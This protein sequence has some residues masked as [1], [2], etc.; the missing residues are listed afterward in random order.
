MTTGSTSTIRHLAIAREGDLDDQSR[1]GRV[2][3]PHRLRCVGR[4]WYQRRQNI[5][6]HVH[7]S[8][9]RR[10]TEAMLSGQGTNV[11]E[12][13]LQGSVRSPRS[14]RCGASDGDH[15]AVHCTGQ[16]SAHSCSNRADGAHIPTSPEEH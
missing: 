2:L 1:A 11:D 16:G 5:T 4:G 10:T 15:G 7:E 3:S 9:L 13:E 12:E 6:S 14:R 8:I